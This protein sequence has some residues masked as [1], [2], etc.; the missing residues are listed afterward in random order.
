MTDRPCCTVSTA[1]NTVDTVYY[2]LSIAVSV[3][4]ALQGNKEKKGAIDLLFNLEKLKFQT[5]LVSHSRPLNYKKKQESLNDYWTGP[6]CGPHRVR[7][8]VL[9]LH[10]KRIK[11]LTCRF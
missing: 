3:A 10:K 2:V 8:G 11:S 6:T 1:H 7:L 9:S 4:F 5:S